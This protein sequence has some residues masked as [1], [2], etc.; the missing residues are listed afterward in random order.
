MPDFKEASRVLHEKGI[1]ARRTN[2]K[3]VYDIDYKAVDD[4]GITFGDK[5]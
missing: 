5:F 4:N 1:E 2:G 3:K